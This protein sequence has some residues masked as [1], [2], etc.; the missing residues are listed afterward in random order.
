MANVDVVDRREIEDVLSRFVYSLDRLDWESFEKCMTEDFRYGYRETHGDRWVWFS[1][2]DEMMRRIRPVSESA[3]VSQHFCTN[4]LV[5][6]TGATATLLVNLIGYLWLPQPD[7]EP[8]R[9]K[10]V[11]RW[12]CELRRT[13]DDGWRLTGV[14][15]EP[16][17][18]EPWLDDLSS[19][20]PRGDAAQTPWK[21]QP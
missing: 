9:H 2:R 21:S 11:G 6:I 10:V 3:V 18:H 17:F 7:A 4:P 13:D 8:R 15:I 19:Y 1:G 16:T 12:E 20:P 14:A 5:E